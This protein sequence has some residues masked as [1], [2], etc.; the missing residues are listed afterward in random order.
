MSDY[1][2]GLKVGAKLGNGH[3]GEVFMGEDPAH[4]QVAVKI[5][6][7]E[8]FHD[9]TTWPT[10]KESYLAEAQNLSKA[11]HRNVVKVHHVVEASDGE[12]VLICMAFCSGGSLQKSFENGPMT[13]SAVRKI[14]TEVLM[15]L[16][17]MHARGMIHRDI[18]PANLL[19]N[20]RSEAQLSDFGLV[21]DDL[22]L[23]YA[24]QAGYSDHIA[25]EVWNGKGTSVRSDIWALGMTLFRLLHGKIWYEAAP[26]P[27]HVVEHGGFANTLKWLPHIPKPWRRAIRKML[28]DDDSAR[29]QNAAQALAGLSNLPVT[30]VWE[31]AVALDSVR[32]Q[33]LRGDR[34]IFVE[35][36]RHSPRKHEWKAWS[37]PVGSGRIRQL[38]ASSGAVGARQA[39][40]KLEA[41]FAA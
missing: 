34:R 32:W 27:Q 20:G 31:T 29:Y 12:S 41:F 7:R 4:G 6:R 10:Y 8:K 33:Q 35:W 37:E 21:T 36:Q 17:A 14:G 26:S 5:L 40:S 9:D 11:S 3:F 24:S 18:K 30:P 23:G 28:N 25:Y 1:V 13:L 38:G 22:V 19:L 2:S 15:G 16:G 39:V